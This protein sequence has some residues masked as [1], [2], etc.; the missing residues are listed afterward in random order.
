M[1]K[2]FENKSEEEKSENRVEILIYAADT[3]VDMG[4]PSEEAVSIVNSWLFPD[5]FGTYD[6]S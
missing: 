3:M 2:E 6:F 5:F 1:L 4:I